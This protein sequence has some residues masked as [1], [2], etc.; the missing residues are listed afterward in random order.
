MQVLHVKPDHVDHG[1]VL[2]VLEVVHGGRDV[3]HDLRDHFEPHVL[4]FLS[5]ASVAAGAEDSKGLLHDRRY[6][7]RQ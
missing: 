1:T 7:R 2:V 3:V 5:P 4:Q 6:C